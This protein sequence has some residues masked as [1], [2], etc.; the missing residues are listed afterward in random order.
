MSLTIIQV[1][2]EDTVRRY[3][4]IL[5]D[6]KTK[7]TIRSCRYS[8]LFRYSQWAGI[9]LQHTT[10]LSRFSLLF[11]SV[12]LIW[13]IRNYRSVQSSFCVL[14]LRVFRRDWFSI[15]TALDMGEFFLNL[16]LFLVLFWVFAPKRLH[17][18][19]SF[20]NVIILCFVSHILI[21]FTSLSRALWGSTFP[22]RPRFWRA[23]RKLR[24]VSFQWP[25]RLF[26]PRSSLCSENSRP[27][28][29]RA[30]THSCFSTF[31]M[32]LML[33]RC[34]LPW[35]RSIALSRHCVVRLDFPVG[36]AYSLWSIINWAKHRVIISNL[37]FSNLKVRCYWRSLVYFKVL[38]IL[39]FR[40]SA[41]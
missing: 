13:D 19:R 26:R 40:S 30:S 2:I 35:M 22:L 23:A 34:N 11:T 37:A 20:H 14:L 24:A 18:F 1:H 21:G 25:A 36:I 7:L 10:Q 12:R 33:V 16:G 3:R 38:W 17:A 5:H 39:C 6:T 4:G 31:L 28:S 9:F 27:T 8:D 41:I 15:T 32:I 29:L